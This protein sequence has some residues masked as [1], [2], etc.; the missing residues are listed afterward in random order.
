MRSPIKVVGCGFRGLAT[1]ADT[2]TGGGISSCQLRVGGAPNTLDA[3]ARADK[4]G[5]RCQRYKG[6][7]KRVLDQVLALLVCDEVLN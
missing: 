7:Q 5:G 4:K 2:L 1:T 6:H 3:A